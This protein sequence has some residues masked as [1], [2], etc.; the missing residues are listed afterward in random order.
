MSECTLF[1]KY[2]LERISCFNET[3]AEKFK[4][5]DVGLAET[6][7]LFYERLQDFDPNEYGLCTTKKF[8]EKLSEVH[9]SILDKM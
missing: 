5:I 9:K 1:V 3:I 8:N 6:N 4:K 7:E 2:E